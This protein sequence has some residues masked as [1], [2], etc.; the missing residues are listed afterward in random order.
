V[1]YPKV[2]KMVVSALVAFLIS[3]VY[4]LCAL[5]IPL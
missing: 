5:N 1:F 3:L 2:K 4:L